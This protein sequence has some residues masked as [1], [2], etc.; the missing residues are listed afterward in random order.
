MEINDWKESVEGKKESLAFFKV[1]QALQCHLVQAGTV[2]SCF[3]NEGSIVAVTA[4]PPGT[5]NMHNFSSPA[6][7]IVFKM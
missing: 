4:A 1:K 7:S 5:I 3:Q 2:A 6:L